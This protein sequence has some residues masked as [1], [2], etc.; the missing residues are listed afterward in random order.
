[1]CKYYAFREE[2]LISLLE[3]PNVSKTTIKGFVYKI[4]WSTAMF[5]CRDIGTMTQLKSIVLKGG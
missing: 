2:G 3:F 4:I 5:S 1:M